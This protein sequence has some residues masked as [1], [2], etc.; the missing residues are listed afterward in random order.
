MAVKP[1]IKG[2]IK[3]IFR[4]AISNASSVAAIA[5]DPPIADF[6][7]TPQT[8]TLPLSVDFTDLS[9]NDPTSWLWDFGDDETSTEQHPTH[10]YAEAGTYTVSLTATNAGGSDE[11]IKAGY[12]IVV[13]VYDEVSMAQ[14]HYLW[15][16]SYWIYAGPGLEDATVVDLDELRFLG[17]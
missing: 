8:G 2:V 1:I 3:P 12:I 7:G 9:T 15:L 13:E 4:P 17:G 10:E 11:E 16:D 14:F 6:S 5:V